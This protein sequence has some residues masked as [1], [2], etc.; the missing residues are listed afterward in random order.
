MATAVSAV[1]STGGRRR[2]G[3]V[4]RRDRGGD[5]LKPAGRLFDGIP[6]MAIQESKTSG[7]AL[8]EVS[9]VYQG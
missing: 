3:P 5:T 6:S 4:D 8:P 9:E 7:R 1:S 2:Q